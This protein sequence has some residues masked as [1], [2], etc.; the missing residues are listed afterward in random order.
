MDS[1]A[2]GLAPSVPATR[3]PV[4]SLVRGVLEARLVQ[5]A[6]GDV[7]SADDTL[8]QD[9]RSALERLWRRGDRLSRLHA[10]RLQAAGEHDAAAAEA[11]AQPQPGGH[12]THAALDAA[13][14]RAARTLDDALQALPP[15]GPPPQAA[16]SD[17]DA[18][19]YAS[20]RW[21]LALRHIVE[22]STSQHAVRLGLMRCGARVFAPLFAASWRRQPPAGQAV[23]APPIAISPDELFDL[24][25]PGCRLRMVLL[26][27]WTDVRVTWRS[28]NGQFFMLSS[29]LAGRLH[30]IGRRGI[31]RLIEQG[32]IRLLARAPTER[33]TTA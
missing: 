25:H 33:V 27:Q 17:A 24:M 4:S 15:A 28:G 19:P 32:H 29:K 3:P 9:C 11:A 30:S 12:D 5:L 2:H 22:Q 10:R 14:A 23:A 20:D 16:A 26:G 13:S 21:A 6:C 8:R 1:P 18:W 7:A 31:E